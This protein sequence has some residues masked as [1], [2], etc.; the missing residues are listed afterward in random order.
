MG[1][2]APVARSHRHLQH[3]LYR[4]LYGSRAETPQGSLRAFAPGD[5]TTRIRPVT[6]R[7]SLF[8]T[9]IPAPPSVGLTPSLPFCE[10]NDTGFPRSTRLTRMGEV[11][12]IR[13]ER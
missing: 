6:G 10:R 12:S 13:R 7:P 11:L 9:P 1:K 8:P 4:F 5:V 2:I 3:L